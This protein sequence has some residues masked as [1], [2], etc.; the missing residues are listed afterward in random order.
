LNIA[1]SPKERDV[2]V[3]PF[4]RFF[5]EALVACE[6]AG[7]VPEVSHGGLDGLHG[8]RLFRIRI[9]TDVCVLGRHRSSSRSAKRE[10]TRVSK[11]PTG[12]LQPTLAASQQ[13][14]MPLASLRLY[15]CPRC[16]SRGHPG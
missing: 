2:V 8:V 4:V 7:V 3:D 11:E 15:L 6:G 13:S 5:R 10:H 9:Q 14:R 16:L 1:M 12:L